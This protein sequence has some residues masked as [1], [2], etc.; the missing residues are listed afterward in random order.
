MNNNTE[1]ILQ[2]CLELLEQGISVEECLNRYP[3]EASDLEP[4]LR[5]AAASK[6]AFMQ[7]ASAGARSRI[8]SR[9]M[10]EWDKQH[11]Q[12]SFPWGLPVFMPRWAATALLVIL[13][14]LL[15][16]SGTV[17]ASGGAVPGEA[18]YPVK[19]FREGA[20]LFFTRSPQE[21]VSLQT[22]FIKERAQELQELAVEK[23]V[24]KEAINIALGRLDQHL[25]S[26]N[27]LATK[28]DS[29]KAAGIR[30]ELQ[31]AITEQKAVHDSLQEILV[32]APPEARPGLEKA[33]QL[34]ERGRERVRS[35]L[36]EL[37]SS[38]PVDS[39]P[40]DGDK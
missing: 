30:R 2:E 13:V 19:E 4:L 3:E 9:V 14:I 5:T 17:F 33:L 40:S 34:I 28:E 1:E 22:Q 24:N 18:L 25:S 32:D 27:T 8:R 23:E 20:Q 37:K 29:K 7:S 38:L 12:R 31:S 35:A 16:G 10:D 39:P 26:I 21:Q 6:G 36:E 11:K 15:G